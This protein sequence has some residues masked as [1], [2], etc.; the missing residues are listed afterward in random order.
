MGGF[1]FDKKLSIYQF[2]FVFAIFSLTSK[3][4]FRKASNNPNLIWPIR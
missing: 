2:F 4:K 3:P 1:F